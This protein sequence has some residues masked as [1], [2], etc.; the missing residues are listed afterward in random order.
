MTRI[1]IDPPDPLEAARAL[2]MA[3][4]VVFDEELGIVAEWNGSATFNTY[5]VDGTALDCFTRY[6][7]RTAEEARGRIEAYFDEIRREERD[8]N[9]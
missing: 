2:H 4:L 9:A 3:R 1:G 6:G 5:E 7:L 8:G